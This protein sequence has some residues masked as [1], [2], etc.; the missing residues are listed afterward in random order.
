MIE[1]GK[2]L[3]KNITEANIR[4]AKRDEAYREVFE[5]FGITE[6]TK[7]DSLAS[8]T[9]NSEHCKLLRLHQ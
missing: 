3:P 7:E 9:L 1:R 4:N 6:E 2:S 5:K 8:Q